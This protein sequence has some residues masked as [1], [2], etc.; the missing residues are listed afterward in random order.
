MYVCHTY[1]HYLTKSGVVRSASILEGGK[2]LPGRARIHKKQSS[3]KTNE[4]IETVK[5]HKISPVSLA[6][7]QTFLDSPQDGDDSEVIFLQ[8]FPI[9]VEYVSLPYYIVE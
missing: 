8:Q 6:S 2:D 1:V 9:I 5:K 3:N 4:F 7:F